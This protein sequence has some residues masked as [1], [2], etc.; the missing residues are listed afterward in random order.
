MKTR[1]AQLWVAEEFNYGSQKG[2]IKEARR[3]QLWEAEGFIYGNQK[4]TFI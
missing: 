4:G 3:V 1:R 2:P